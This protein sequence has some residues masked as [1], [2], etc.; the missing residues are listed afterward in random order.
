MKLAILDDYQ[1][2]AL[3]MADWSA[4]GRRCQIDIIDRP[5]AVPEEAARVLAPYDIICMLRERTPAPRALLERLPNLKLLAITGLQHRTLDLAAAT[6]LG[7]LVSHSSNHPGAHTGTP[8][9][10]IAL[11]L[12]AIR[13]IPQEDRRTREGRWQGS[14]GTQV[15]GRTLGIVGLGK[16]GRR[17]ARAAQALDMNVVAWSQNLTEASAAEA[18]VRRVEKGE[19]FGTSD[20]VTLHL[21]LSDRTRGVVGAQELSL[22]KPSAHIVNTA[23]GPL[24]D[25]KALV[26]ALQQRRIA[27]AALDVYWEEPIPSDHPLLALDNV[28][29]TPHLGYVVEESY[30][31]FYGDLVEQVTAWLDGKPIRVSNPTVKPR[32]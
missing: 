4:L 1:H 22:M 14:L 30:R 6:D 12:A 13:R 32:A 16:I 2:V 18:G 3:E 11:M 21:V 10:T 7:I 5:L 19:L 23:R 29:L 15:Y 24:I 27:G 9:L 25:E 8:E 17:V 26:E 20:I 28:V 31:A